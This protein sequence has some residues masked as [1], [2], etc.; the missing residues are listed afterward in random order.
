MSP[1]QHLPLI[2]PTGDLWTEQGGGRPALALQ[3]RAATATPP[4]WTPL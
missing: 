4:F 2:R 1:E 3:H